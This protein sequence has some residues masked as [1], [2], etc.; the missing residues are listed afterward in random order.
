MRSARII[1]TT[2]KTFQ[3]YQNWAEIISS[4]AKKRIPAEFILRDGTRFETGRL[5]VWHELVNEIFFEHVYTPVPLQ[6]ERHDVVV[7]I[8]A[9]I[10]VFSVFAAS[11]T[12][13]TIYAFEPFPHNFEVLKRNIS[14]NGV[15]NILPSRCAVSDRPG[16][17]TLLLSSA[18]S[19]NHLLSNHTILDKLEEYQA[20][21]EHLKYKSAMPGE[22]RDCIEVPT[23]TLQDI[24]DSNN[25]EQIDF[26]KMDCEG[27]EELILTSTPKNYLKR[28][29]KIAFE[30]HDHL[31]KI[32]HD[33]MRKLLEELGFTTNLK[34]DG[35]SPVGFLYG[36]RDGLSPS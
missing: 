14:V 21:T 11:M 30:F 6:I 9:H 1:G 33:E 15:N 26:L 22:L 32:N 20:S 24:I 28:V 8:G 31:S 10:G 12:Q 35:K 2:V 3:K 7:D 18:S 4:R 36:W 34:W 25:L 17:T 29:R 23:T 27:S 13:N 5:L 16:S 19:T